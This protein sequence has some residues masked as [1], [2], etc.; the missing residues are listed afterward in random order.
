[1][2]V[3]KPCLVEGNTCGSRHGPHLEDGFLIMGTIGKDL[4][5]EQG[6]LAAG[7]PGLD[8]PCYSKIPSRQPDK[9]R[10]VIKVLG[11]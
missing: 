3:Y 10:R 4:D 11:W 8:D 1:M 2:G 9:V 5:I 7:R 6:K